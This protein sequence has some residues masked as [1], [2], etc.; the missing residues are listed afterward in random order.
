ML[1]LPN[2]AKLLELLIVVEQALAACQRQVEPT[3]A[4]VISPPLH[5]HGGKLARDHRVEQRQIFADELLLQTDG[6]R[7]D[8]DFRRWRFIAALLAIAAPFGFSLRGRKNRRH[9]IGKAFS[10]SGT[11]LGDKMMLC[12]NRPGDRLGHL[13]LLRPLLIVRQPSRDAA[14]GAKDIGGG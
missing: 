14:P 3:Q 10:N 11:R 8:D 7:R 1:H 2:L 9:E 5:Q 4:D 12:R 13:Q 6:V